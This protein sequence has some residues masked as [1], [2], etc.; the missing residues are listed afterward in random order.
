[1]QWWEERREEIQPR[2]NMEMAAILGQNN[3]EIDLVLVIFH[4]F[5]L[6]LKCNSPYPHHNI[7]Q[8]H[9]FS[10]NLTPPAHLSPVVHSV[11]EQVLTVHCST[12]V[13]CSA[14]WKQSAVSCLIIFVDSEARVR[15][16]SFVCHPIVSHFTARCSEALS[17]FILNQKAHL[18]CLC[19]E[20]VTHICCTNMIW[21]QKTSRC[22]TIRVI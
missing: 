19:K 22:V 2:I 18:R 9:I 13:Q 1:M 17:A 3:K 7:R 12:A 20:I 21:N 4:K 5:N 11:S 6:N 14:R 15:A 10:Y 16:G 8:L